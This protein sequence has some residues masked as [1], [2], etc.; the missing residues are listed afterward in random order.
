MMNKTLVPL[1]RDLI[2]EHLS[3]KRRRAGLPNAEAVHRVAIMI[4]PALAALLSALSVD[5][6][7]PRT[8]EF[9]QRTPIDYTDGDLFSVD[10]GPVVE[11]ERDSIDS[12]IYDDDDDDMALDEDDGEL[13][14]D[15]EEE[16]E[17]EEEDDDD[18]E[19]S[20]N[21]HREHPFW[22]DDEA[23]EEDED[24]DE[25]ERSHSS[26]CSAMSRRVGFVGDEVEEL[27]RKQ[28]SLVPVARKRA[29]TQTKA[30]AIAVLV[31]AVFEG[32]PEF[33]E[34]LDA[35]YSVFQTSERRNLTPL[36]AL[37]FWAIGDDDNVELFPPSLGLR[38]MDIWAKARIPFAL[39][40]R[41]A[42]AET[43]LHIGRIDVL[44]W[45][46]GA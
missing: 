6:L 40:K 25:D 4:T 23:E 27:T 21:G 38:K 22:L 32:H 5:D 16:E 45:P 37:I 13:G 8:A 43:G 46:A 39:E 29:A 15:D 19:E 34:A 18:D 35:A 1:R 14:E 24:D 3:S 20:R 33:M 42:H 10:E 11:I 44:V 28:P 2:A 41:D 31:F 12:D 30:G 17:E 36:L 26:S 9:M 7:F